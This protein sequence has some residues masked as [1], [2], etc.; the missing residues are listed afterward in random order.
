V[1]VIEEPKQDLATQKYEPTL[2]D[3]HE[4]YVKGVR[5]RAFR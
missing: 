4:K 3:W 1:K 2:L 5:S